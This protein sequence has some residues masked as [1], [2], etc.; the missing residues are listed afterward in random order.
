[1]NIIMAYRL[2]HIQNNS[3]Y[4]S[5]LYGLNHETDLAIVNSDM[6]LPTICI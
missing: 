3:W 4:V 5:I 6:L 1:M 2:V